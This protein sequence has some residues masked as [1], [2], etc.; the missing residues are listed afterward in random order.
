M[1]RGSKSLGI[2]KLVLTGGVSSL[3]PTQLPPIDVAKMSGLHRIW[4]QSSSS[5][6]QLDRQTLPGYTLDNLSSQTIGFDGRL[7]DPQQFYGVSLTATYDNAVTDA[8]FLIRDGAYTD[9]TANGAAL[10]RVSFHALGH[11]TE[12]ATI[13]AG[14]GAG[15]P[16]VTALDVWVDKGTHFVW[17]T[18]FTS[19]LG[20]VLGADPGPD[21]GLPQVQTATVTGRGGALVDLT[22]NTADVH[23][24]GGRGND[25]VLVRMAN[26][27]VA[28]HFDGGHGHDVFAIS[29]ADLPA[30]QATLSLSGAQ[31]ARANAVAQNFEI[32]GIMG[33][34]TR[35]IMIDAARVAMAREIM[36]GQNAEIT[37]IADDQQI[38][39]QTLGFFDLF[40][41][42]TLVLQHDSDAGGLLTGAGT[43]H[44][45]GGDVLGFGGFLGKAFGSEQLSGTAH[46]DDRSHY[47]RLEASGHYDLDIASAATWTD[48]GGVAHGV[49]VAASGL[50]GTLMAT[51][52][53]LDDTLIGGHGADVLTGGHGDDQVD[54]GAGNDVLKGGAGADLLGG[55]RGADRLFGGGQAD[56]LG[57]GGGRDR[58]SGD[59]GSDVLSGGAGA[60][61]L[62][63]GAGADRLSG[64]AGNDRLTG[65][66]GPDTFVF[67]PHGGHDRVTDFRLADDTLHLARV[68]VG[69]GADAASVV[70]DDATV[71]ASGVDFAFADGTT[72]HLVGLT[73]TVGLDAHI[74]IVG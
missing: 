23:F 43:I 20:K 65:G 52:T 57:G 54:G 2:E 49:A 45:A 51:G 27:T 31:Y 33:D 42:S 56:H 18:A 71:T 39:F 4:F 61:K 55:G 12:V 34:F 14:D 72:V 67:G 70:A 9:V 35:T 8:H 10:T 73:T 69:A 17:L 5:Y 36:V 59:T 74:L 53:Q 30:S 15:L 47:A 44:L 41:H 29:L 3:R 28:D 6:G 25:A 26:T 19:E 40:K 22:E 13:L 66:A 48:A 37:H 11:G 7:S 68:L 38:D 16:N 60:D 32:F 62:S 50:Y 46:L 58:L 63:G 64:N 1:S 24:T 21:Y